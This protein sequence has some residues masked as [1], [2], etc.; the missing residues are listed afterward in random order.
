MALL[1]GLAM[2]A[3]SG[4][5]KDEAKTFSDQAVAAVRDAI[6]AGW[7]GLKELKEPDFEPLRERDDFKLLLTELEAKVA[8]Q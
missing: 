7:R 1:A 6:I 5:T 2:D 8:S 3:N 4:V